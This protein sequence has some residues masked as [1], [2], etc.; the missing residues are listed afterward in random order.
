MVAVAVN[1]RVMAQFRMCG[2]RRVRHP[3]QLYG[4]DNGRSVRGRARAVAAASV[5]PS[6]RQPAL[7]D[8][9][10][11]DVNGNLWNATGHA[12]DALALVCVEKET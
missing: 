7:H 10:R 11:D 9:Q 12:P 4:L 3:R 5:Q 8:G 1:A 2:N 6:Q